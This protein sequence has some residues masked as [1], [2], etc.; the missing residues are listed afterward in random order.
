MKQLHA[1]LL[2][3]SLVCL[4]MFVVLLYRPYSRQLHHD[5]KAVAGLLSQLPAEVDVEGHVKT[6]VLG[7]NSTSAKQGSMAGQS[8]VAMS[9]PGGFAVAGMGQMGG[10]IIPVGDYE[11]QQQAFA[12]GSVGGMGMNGRGVA[13][14]SM[15]GSWFGRKNGPPAQGM[16]GY[17]QNPGIG[18]D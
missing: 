7:I 8:S 16:L 12:M 5:S 11:A 14:N 2:V 17:R 10:M 3:L 15:G 18:Y 9:M 1:I 13:G 4:V 6:V